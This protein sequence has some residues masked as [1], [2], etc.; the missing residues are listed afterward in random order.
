MT[1]QWSLFLLLLCNSCLLIGQIPDKLEKYLTKLEKAVAN[2]SYNA[3]LKLTDTDYRK[4]QHDDF[5]Q[6]NTKQF[7]DELLSGYSVETNIFVNHTLNDI[8]SI[9]RSTIHAESEN[10][11][12]VAYLLLSD[13]NPPINCTLHFV[14]RTKKWG[15]VG[16]VG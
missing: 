3:V 4:E 1:K 9:T 15:I 2:H 5:L 12:Y 7:V 11:V 13:Y 14:K 10:S 16:A 6:G 8:S